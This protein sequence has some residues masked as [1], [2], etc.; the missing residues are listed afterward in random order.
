MILEI[1][2]ELTFVL[3]RRLVGVLLVRHKISLL[4]NV[5]SAPLDTS[6]LKPYFDLC[7]AQMQLVCQIVTLAAHHILLPL[8]FDFEFVKLILGE[9][10]AYSLRILRLLDAQFGF[11]LV[12]GLHQFCV[13]WLKIIFRFDSRCNI[14]Q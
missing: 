10:R 13:Y 12:A 2:S 1:G 11:R 3:I 4:V 6:I 14:S 9:Y 5:F 8:E 7:L